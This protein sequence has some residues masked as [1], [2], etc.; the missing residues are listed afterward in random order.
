MVE[1]LRDPG[2]RGLHHNLLTSHR[3]PGRLAQNGHTGLRNSLSCTS[4][5]GF[6]SFATICREKAPDSGSIFIFSRDGAAELP[7]AS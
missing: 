6:G 4:V 3:I 5:P 7:V 2:E 1:F